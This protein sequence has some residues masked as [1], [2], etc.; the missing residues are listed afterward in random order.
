MTVTAS[1]VREH[2]PEFSTATDTLIELWLAQA[3]R[4]VNTTQWGEKA[5]DATLWLT[6][7]LLKI[8]CQIRGGGTPVAGPISSE[9][10]GDL[11]RTYSVPGGRLKDS[12]LAS[13][14]YGQQYL[15][16][17]KEMIGTRVLDGTV[18][19]NTGCCT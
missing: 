10:V 14:V 19:I 2:F 13:T 4:R 11:S 18:T 15:E 8:D 12:F 6:A 3:E 9:R 1:D 5:D 16:M 17:R 7:H